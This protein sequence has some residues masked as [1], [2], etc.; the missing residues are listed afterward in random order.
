MTIPD[1]V[2]SIGVYAF[3]RCSALKSI[4]LP[5]S[6]TSCSNDAFERCSALFD[7]Y[8]RGTEAQK[9]ERLGENLLTK[10]TWHYQEE[11]EVTIDSTQF[12]D[13]TFCEAVKTFDQDGN[14]SL[15]Q[16]EL[17][18][19]T[20]INCEGKNLQSLEGIQCFSK[21]QK[22]N[23]SGNQLTELN[24]DGFEH[25]QELDCHDNQIEELNLSQSTEL[26]RLST[27]GNKITSLDLRG[28]D[29]L[30]ETVRNGK[31]NAVQ[32]T[33]VEYALEGTENVVRFDETVS[34]QPTIFSDN[35]DPDAYFHDAVYW[36]V[37]QGITSG[38]TATTFAPYDSCTRAQVMA[39]LYKASGSPEVSGENPFTDVKE[40]DYFYKPVLWAVSQGITSGTS[41]TTFSPYNTCTRAQVMA[42]LYKANGSPAVSGTNPFT[43]VKESDYF[44]NAVLWAVANG[45]TSGTSA[46]TFGPYN[47]CRRAQVMTFLYKAMN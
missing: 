31:R 6:L 5:L 19:V 47:T 9:N 44:Y 17:D 33:V 26:I 14:G 27:Y 46:T 12:P 42:F 30:A 25:L 39:F 29:Q 41:P 21:L 2:T 8:Y 22:L 36:A 13:D 23:C 43:D 32:N 20:E 1:G 3:E 4:T 34:I 28:C 40:S 24:L 45:I 16:E 11:T 35:G 10:A 7:V 37:D 15:S 18:R 38:K